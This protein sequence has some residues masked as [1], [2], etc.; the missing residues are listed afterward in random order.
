MNYTDWND[1]NKYGSLS[2][3]Q[4]DE[5]CACHEI[6][7]PENYRLFLLGVNG[8]NP[9]NKLFAVNASRKSCLH[10]VYGIHNGPKHKTLESALNAARLQ[11]IS[12]DLLPI[13]DDEGGNLLCLGISEKNWNN[14]Y[15]WDH[16]TSKL[17]Q[18]SNDFVEFIDRLEFRFASDDL[19]AIFRADNVEGIA[20]MLSEGALNLD[21][22]DENG[23]GLMEN[24]AIYK[25]KNIAQYL[26]D[27]GLP[28]DKALK[29][30]N[31]NLVFFPET[32]YMVDLLK[33][34]SSK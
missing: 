13:A 27:C 17:F 9:K 32:K 11:K 24:A 23:R 16:E 30:A 26:Y 28:T 33:S 4:L 14:V 2:Q 8:G 6:Q 29:I 19:E 7:L 20:G 25:S 10:H 1:I 31:E 34:L 18:I 5:F 3:S 22:L 21:Y 12:D 15:F